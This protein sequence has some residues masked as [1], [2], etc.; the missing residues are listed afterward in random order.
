[1]TP[2]DT[3]DPQAVKAYPVGYCPDARPFAD[4]QAAGLLCPWQH[5]IERAPLRAE[6]DE[7]SCPVFGHDCPGGAAQAAACRDAAGADS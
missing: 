1:M 5:C 3:A 4:W 2:Q 6:R 7:H